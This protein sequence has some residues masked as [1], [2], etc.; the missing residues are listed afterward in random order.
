MHTVPGGSLELPN[1][2]VGRVAG[3]PPSRNANDRGRKVVIAA[4]LGRRGSESNGLT[5]MSSLT[6]RHPTALEQRALATDRLSAGSALGGHSSP[7]LRS[8]ALSLR[9]IR[10][11][12]QRSGIR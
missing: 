12:L 3:P 11:V 5:C 9:L 8:V 1:Q 7:I 10:P 4:G 2:H 6:Q